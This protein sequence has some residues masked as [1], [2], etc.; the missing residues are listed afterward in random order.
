[1]I[2]VMVG[3][4][5][6]SSE[7]YHYY[8]VLGGDSNGIVWVKHATSYGTRVAIIGQIKAI[9][10]FTHFNAIVGTLFYDTV[11]QLKL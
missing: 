7:W 5:R 10:I 8:V 2:T 9:L 11:K 1:M 3:D 6:F 4:Y